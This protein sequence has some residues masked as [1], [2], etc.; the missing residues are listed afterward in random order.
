[1]PPF[2]TQG[3]DIGAGGFRHPQLI[4][5]EEGDQRVVC[6]AAEPGG[7]ERR[8]PLVAVQAGGM[9][10]VAQARAADVRGR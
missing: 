4:E 10:L 7:D 8:A 6:R 2:G 1:V 9:R 5:G 3:L